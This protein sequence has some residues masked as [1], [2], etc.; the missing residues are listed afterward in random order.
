MGGDA[1]S[2][3]PPEG[4]LL[5]QPSCRQRNTSLGVAV[6]I[7]DGEPLL[8]EGLA[9]DLWVEAQR[10]SQPRMLVERVVERYEPSADLTE[11]V[12]RALDMVRPL[13]VEVSHARAPTVAN[14]REAPAS[15]EFGSDHAALGHWLDTSDGIAAV[16]VASQVTAGRRAPPVHE[17]ADPAAAA[18]AA[19][20][21]RVL[22]GLTRA[23]PQGFPGLDPVLREGID[24]LEFTMQ[25]HALECEQVLLDV[26][27]LGNTLGVDVRVLKGMATAHL[28]Y[29]TPDLRQ[30]GD[31]DLLVA[32][33]DHPAII[34]GLKQR[35][36]GHITGG[37]PGPF[38]LYKSN[39]LIAPNN[40][41][42]DL[43]HR[44]FRH[45][46]PHHEV[47]NDPDEFLIEGRPVLAPPRHWRLLHAAVHARTSNGHARH[48]SGLVDQVR[49]SLTWPDAVDEALAAA[50]RIDLAKLVARSMT[51]AFA[52]LDVRGGRP[53][54]AAPPSGVRGHVAEWAFGDDHRHAGREQLSLLLG[55][56]PT[57]AARWTWAW[58]SPDAGYRG[59]SVG[60]RARSAIRSRSRNP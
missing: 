5:T 29:P 35:G 34:E 20:R 8:L 38:E 11:A 32:V 53:S 16:L 56:S 44:L 48:A 50:Q 40:I 23:F 9:A 36:Y 37:D 54:T 42:V 45:G 6:A 24:R 2:G 21:E 25:L 7:G 33:D 18:G 15:I 19:N 58:F 60:Q 52:A 10:P 26:L 49:L 27:D 39:Y 46:R 59:P 4:P 57:D 13:L 28:D 31:V 1:D 55:L 51:H 22:P 17:L 3:L 14:P 47:W 43:H 41:E 30:I 12:A